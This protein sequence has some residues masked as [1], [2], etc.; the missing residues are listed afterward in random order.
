IGDGG[1]ALGGAIY[2]DGGIINLQNVTFASNSA[3][4][5]QPMLDGSMF[6]GLGGSGQGGAVYLTNSTANL[7][8]LDFSANSAV[9]GPITATDFR[10]SGTGGDGLGGAVFLASGSSLLV[11]T[12]SFGANRAVGGLGARNGNGGVARGGALFNAG[13]VQLF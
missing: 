12:S 10:F 7:I 5:A 2:S 9:G 8:S 6:A 4:G 3:K 13:E 11:R 1:A